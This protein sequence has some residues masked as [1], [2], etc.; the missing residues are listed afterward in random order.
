MSLSPCARLLHRTELIHIAVTAVSPSP[1]AE[2][3]RKGPKRPRIEI[4]ESVA[5]NEDY[6]P[7]GSV[8]TGERM[9]LPSGKLETKKAFEKRM[10]EARR[11]VKEQEKLEREQGKVAASQNPKG[12]R[13]YISSLVIANC[14]SSMGSPSRN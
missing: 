5:S 12:E 11:L 1:S 9:M 8:D 13:R 14:V 6:T 10:V 4:A 3:P 7:G 2:S